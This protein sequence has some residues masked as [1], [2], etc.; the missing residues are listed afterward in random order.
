LQAKRGY[1]RFQLAAQRTFA[2]DDEARGGLDQRHG[3]DQAAMARAID[4]ALAN[5]IAPELLAQAIRPFEE[6]A[7]IAAH[8][9][10]LGLKSA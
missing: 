4:H 9:E 7:I 5:P 1:L 2:K 6:S 10:L 3:G 8:F